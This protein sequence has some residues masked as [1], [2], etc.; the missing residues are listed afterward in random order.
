VDYIGDITLGIDKQA[1]TL[2]TM[3]S[4][5]ESSFA[6][7]DDE[8]GEYDLR[9]DCRTLYNG[10]EKHVALQVYVADSTA[11][12]LVISFGENRN[13]DSLVVTYWYVDDSPFFKPPNHEDM[14]E[15]NYQDRKHFPYMAVKKASKY[16]LKVMKNY[17]IERKEQKK[18]YS[19]KAASNE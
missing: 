17:Y 15:E 14:T 18:L 13:S 10:R 4:N 2:L 7:F 5:E 19:K 9:V 1:W 12:H 3:L 8:L 11:K 16:I 6:Q